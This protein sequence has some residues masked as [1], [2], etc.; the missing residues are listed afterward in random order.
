MGGVCKVSTLPFAWLMRTRASKLAAGGGGDLSWL[1]LGGVAEK[2][3]AGRVVHSTRL[4]TISTGSVSKV[5][6][7]G[8]QSVP[9][10]FPKQFESVTK[11]LVC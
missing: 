1:G 4:Y 5:F 11:V 6:P 3:R 7:K 10:V 2:G 9:K 8:S